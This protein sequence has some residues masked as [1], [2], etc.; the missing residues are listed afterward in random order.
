MPALIRPCGVIRGAQMQMRSHAAAEW[1]RFIPVTAIVET[2][3]S[4]P[5]IDPKWSMRWVCWWKKKK[6]A[7]SYAHTHTTTHIDTHT[8]PCGSYGQSCGEILWAP[9]IKMVN[10][11]FSVVAQWLK[12]NTKCLFWRANLCRGNSTLTCLK[13]QACDLLVKSYL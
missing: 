10:H 13:L 3:R 4:F 6:K 11:L 7:F 2:L 12:I 9:L 1:F 5:G 8:L